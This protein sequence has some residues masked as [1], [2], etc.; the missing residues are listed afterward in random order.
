M[1]RHA[2]ITA[3]EAAETGGGHVD[4]RRDR[5]DVDRRVDVVVCV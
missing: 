4:P 5:G 1:E 2:E 3:E